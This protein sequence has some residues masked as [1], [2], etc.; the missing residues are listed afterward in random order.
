MADVSVVAGV[1]ELVCRVSVDLVDV[2]VFWVSFCSD[3]GK[4]NISFFGSLDL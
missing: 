1:A 2:F 4:V 3:M